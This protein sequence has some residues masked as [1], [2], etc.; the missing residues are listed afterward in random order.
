MPELGEYLDKMLNEFSIKPILGM[1]T[2]VPAN[3]LSMFFTTSNGL[4]L[5][6]ASDGVNF[7]LNRKKMLCNKSI[8]YTGW[9]GGITVS[10]SEYFYL[11]VD[12]LDDSTKRLT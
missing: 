12:S 6:Y 8:G 3:S 1:K 11:D 4:I 9:G 10:E 2:N 7:D 5:T